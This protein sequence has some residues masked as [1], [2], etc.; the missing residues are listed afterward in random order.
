MSWKIEV[1]NT[2]T[3]EIRI[4]FPRFWSENEVL[5]HI[6]LLET[7]RESDVKEI[8]DRHKHMQKLIFKPLEVDSKQKRYVKSNKKKRHISTYQMKERG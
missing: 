4:G 6:K 3:G 2:E 5:E 8:Y 7:L 1:T